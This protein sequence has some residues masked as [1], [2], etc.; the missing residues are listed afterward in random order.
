ML[1]EEYG[2]KLIR[3]DLPFRLN[4]VNCF[5]AEGEGGWKVIDAGLHN[6][7]TVNRWE[8]ELAGKKVTDILVTHYHP[9]HFGYV[10]GL[11]EITGARVSMTKIDADAGMESWQEHSIN[12]LQDNYALA[13]IPTDTASQMTTNTNDFVSLVT[14]YPKVNHY[15]EEGEI[16]EIGKYEYEVI[17][18][19]GHSDGMVNFYNKEKNMLLST[20]HILPKI[21]PNISYWFHG[22]ANPLKRYMESL[23][24]IRK[25]DVDF[26]VPSHGKPFHGAN[27]RIDEIKAHHDERLEQ[28]LESING[29]AT[30]H[31]SCQKL[32]Q[33]ELTVH[34]TRFA[35]GETLAHLEYL[36]YEGECKRE[37]RDGKYW[38]YT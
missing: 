38:Y 18:T 12:K 29:G 32:F 8:Q 1:L 17:V 7:P 34:E 11:Q 24:K 36:R 28:T 31:G 25:L 5:L 15:F 16:V 21:T 13:G 37:M 10:G 19:P 20:D 2:L 26:V 22:D 14:P 35:I 9:D 4:H 27:D 3:L 23:E 6:P 33:K 30:I